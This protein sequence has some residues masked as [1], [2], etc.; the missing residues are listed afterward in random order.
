MMQLQF[1]KTD[2][3][4]VDFNVT[5]IASVDCPT[6]S[7]LDALHQP[8]KRRTVQFFQFGIVPNQCTCP[9]CRET[10]RSWL[11]EKYGALD[12]LN[13]AWGDEV[14]SGEIS[15]WEQIQPLLG[16]DNRPDCYNPA[17]LL[18]YERFCAQ[19]TTDFVRFQC[20]IIRSFDPQAVITT[21]ACFPQH[22]PDFHK[23]FAPLGVAS[24][25]NYP[26]IL[27]P[28]NPEEPYSN[29]FALDFVP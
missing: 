17:Y 21:N 23:E 29:A 14:W 2:K 18:D 13:E 9:A 22:M 7:D 1:H 6:L 12:V 19:S 8:Q 11:K 20:D 5:L 28:E 25:D 10:F 3:I 16:K 26:P 24:Y 27:L 15:D 4:V